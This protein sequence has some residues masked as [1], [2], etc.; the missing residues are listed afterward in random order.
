MGRKKNYANYEDLFMDKSNIRLIR[1]I[2]AKQLP[3]A[4]FGDNFQLSQILD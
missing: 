3:R 2:H 1:A 4:M